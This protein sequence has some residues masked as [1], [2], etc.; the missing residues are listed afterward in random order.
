MGVRGFRRLSDRR[1][2]REKEREKKMPREGMI[3][4]AKERERRGKERRGRTR[5]EMERRS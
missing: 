4:R 5:K 3:Y 2:K 1:R